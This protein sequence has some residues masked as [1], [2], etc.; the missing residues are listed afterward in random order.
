M[1]GIFGFFDFTKPG[2]G[3]DPDEPEKRAVFRYLDILWQ[4]KGKLIALNFFYFV[5]I[6]PIILAFYLFL[7]EPFMTR[8]LGEEL[9]VGTL[10]V[11]M[12][13]FI[14][15]LPPP[16]LI[17]LMAVSVFLLGPVTCGLTYVLRNFVRREHAWVSDFWQRAKMNFKQG[18]FLGI[19]DALMFYVGFFNITLFF[20]PVY[21]VPTFFAVGAIVVFIIFL[22]MRNT[23]YL[24][25][26]TVELTNFQLLR[27]AFLLTFDG[28]WRHLLT[29][30]IYT[31]YIV[32]ILLI[33]PYVELFV[34]P[35]LGFSLLGF[36]SVFICYPLV[37]KRL[38]LP[39]LE[40]AAESGEDGDDQ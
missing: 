26:V 22:C 31:I 8:L 30:F 20:D 35:L 25:A 7:Y 38:I 1:A 23:L 18:L 40:R 15:S 10:F 5:C 9:L 34:L 19:V 24:M 32:L 21:E 2:K 14:F 3:V 16:V 12:F 29:G 39:H 17:L 37:H 27:N 36:T 13:A 4:K 28:L 11:A 6:L 33:N